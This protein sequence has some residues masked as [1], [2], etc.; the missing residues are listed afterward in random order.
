MPDLS[1]LVINN[2]DLIEQSI[3]YLLIAYIGGNLLPNK[4]VKTITEHFPLSDI[5]V[6]YYNSSLESKKE[7]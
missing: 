3:E 6:D 1:E 2:A 5:L 4:T 7:E